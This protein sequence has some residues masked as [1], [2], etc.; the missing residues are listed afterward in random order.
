MNLDPTKFTVKQAK[1]MGLWPPQDNIGVAIAPYVGRMK[2]NI[3]VL[4]IGV[5]KG[6]SIVYL[7]EKTQNIVR[8]FGLSHNNDYQDILLENIKDISKVDRG[9]TG[10]EVDVVLITAL[11][12]TTAELL[13][14]Y[15]SKVK[16]G[17][18]FA[19]DCHDQVF[20]K[21]VLGKF[22]RDNKIGIP[23]QV[24]NKTIWFWMKK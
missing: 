23:I 3:E 11:P 24:V 2:G 18:F 7:A 19:G 12:D 14:Q 4:D 5:N 15:Y 13:S 16:I 10:Q 21:E 1:Q 6:E 20:M 9:Y 8:F 22:R 17:G